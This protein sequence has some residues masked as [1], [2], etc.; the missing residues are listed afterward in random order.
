MNADKITSLPLSFA[1]IASLM[2]LFPALANGQELRV[3][4]LDVGVNYTLDIVG[5]V[6]SI[7]GTQYSIRGT[8][9]SVGGYA[10][11]NIEFPYSEYSLV[12]GGETGVDLYLARPQDRTQY[13]NGALYTNGRIGMAVEN[14]HVYAGYGHLSNIV[15]EIHYDT[16]PGFVGLDLNFTGNL[17]GSVRCYHVDVAD[18]ISV[19][20]RLSF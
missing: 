1:I 7:S 19:S 15:N 2:S 16:Y 13:L 18:K 12:F 17:I 6:F 5:V 3:K 9:H 4:P 10:G 11:L 14:V 20:M 8:A